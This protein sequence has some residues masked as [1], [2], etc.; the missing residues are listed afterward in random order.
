MGDPRKTPF[1][2][3]SVSLQHSLSGPEPKL[4]QV[5]AVNRKGQ[6]EIAPIPFLNPDPVVHLVGCANEVPV[7]IDGCEVAALIDLG[8]QVSNISVQLCKDLDLEIQPLRQLLELEGTGGAAIPYL[9]FVEVNLQIPGIRGYSEDVLLLAIPTTAYAEGVLVMVGSKIID[10]APSCM[11][12]GELA[13]TNATWQQAHFGAVMSGSLQLC[14]SN[15]DKIKSGEKIG[16]FSQ[17]S[18]PVEVGKSQLDG[19]KGAV[20]TTQK[21]T[22]PPFHMVNVK[23]NASVKGHCMKVHILTEPALGA[24][25]PAAVVLIATY[26]EL[27]PGSSRIPVCLHNLSA[28]AMEI[29]AKTVVGQVIPANQVPPVVHPTRTAKETTNKASKGW[30]LEALD[31]QGLKEWPESEQKQARELLL[32]WE[33]LFVCS[34]P[35]LGKTAL[36]KH[37]IRLTEQMLFKKWYRQIPPHM[38]G[39][40]RAHIQEMLDIGAIHKLHSPWASAVVLVQKKDGGLGFCIDLRKLNK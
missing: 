14:H 26:G 20:C 9:R 40:V 2:Q 31:L 36:I 19:V 39:N 7:V 3:Q 11:T 8:A 4:T 34:N 30:V 38:H 27:H 35:D 23:A 10:R 21:I 37:K 28:H 29:R 6:R 25:L 17:E 33:H 1:Q 15:S 24:Q 16:S 22:I 32:K 18:D 5:K 12:A 13:H